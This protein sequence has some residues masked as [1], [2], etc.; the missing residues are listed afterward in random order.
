MEIYKSRILTLYSTYNSESKNKIRG[1]IQKN[2]SHITKEINIFLFVLGQANG[3][4][5]SDLGE[6]LQDNLGSALPPGITNLTQNF[7]PED[8]EKLLMEKCRKNTGSD[9]AYE[10]AK[11][12]HS[13]LF[14]T[15]SHIYSV[16]GL[17]RSELGGSHGC[18]GRLW[19]RFL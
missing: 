18:T 13:P 4:A 10:K 2:I 5:V 11:A 14:Y 6:Q 17:E 1:P 16:R 7:N 3:D 15:P 8:A 9:E 19:D 12:S